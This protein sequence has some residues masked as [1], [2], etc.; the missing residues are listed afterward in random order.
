MTKDDEEFR[1]RP[2]NPP[3]S[4]RRDNAAWAVL[5]KTVI[6]YA[7][8]SRVQKGGSFARSRPQPNRPYSQRCAVRATYSRNAVAGQWRAHGRYLA[9]DSATGDVKSVEA[10]F[11]QE[12]D[13][14]EIAMRLDEWQ[15]AGDERLWKLIVSPEFGERVDLKSLTRQLL[16]RMELDLKTPLEWVAVGHYNTEHPHVHIAL[17][18][19]DGDGRP[20]RLEREYIKHGIREIA[21]TLCTNQL[22][23]RTELDAEAAQQREVHEHRF[24]SLDR[25]IPNRAIGTG[26]HTDFEVAVKDAIRPDSSKAARLDHRLAQRLMALEGMGLARVLEPGTW[27]VRRDIEDVL[28]SMQRIRDRHKTLAVHGVA[29]SDDRLPVSTLQMHDLKLVEGR[30]LVHGEEES[31]RNYLMLEGTDA[32]IHHLYYTP[33]IEEARAR[34]LMRT[35]SFV[36]LRKVMVTGKPVLEIDDLGDAEAILRNRKHFRESAKQALRQGL[37]TP[38]GTWGGWLG[39]YH[40]A[41]GQAVG[42]LAREGQ[43]MSKTKESARSQG[44]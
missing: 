16:E 37:P 6:H 10:G 15:R 14:V 31:G 41:L 12:R 34:G 24:T 7:R 19:V 42:E 3:K 39:R 38:E 4:G 32:R 18:G 8:A 27:L 33:E 5:F 29:V 1:L 40:S 9:R 36:R 26:P 2:R 11:D 44:R 25:L 22:G 35:N 21:S 23:Y 30:V 17:R 28:R 20:L 43:R 13:T